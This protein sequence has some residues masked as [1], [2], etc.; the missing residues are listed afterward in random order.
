MKQLVKKGRF[1]TEIIVFDKKVKI[2]RLY[3]MD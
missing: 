3:G 1:V 2:N